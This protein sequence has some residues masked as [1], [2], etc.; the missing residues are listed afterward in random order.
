MAIQTE[1]LDKEEQVL[2]LKK[3]KKKKEHRIYSTDGQIRKPAWF[4]PEFLCSL[5]AQVSFC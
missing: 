1:Y 2:S 5:Q 3:E 4:I